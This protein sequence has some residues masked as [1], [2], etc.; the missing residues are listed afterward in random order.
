MGHVMAQL[1]ER[2]TGLRVRVGLAGHEANHQALLSGRIDL[3][4]DYLGT[5][6]RRYLELP[7]VRGVSA[8]YRAVR[9]AA[10]ARWGIEWLSA[11]GFN[12]TYAVIL[13]RE[14]AK[15]LGASR[16]SDLAQHAAKTRLGGT[17]QF[18]TSDA[19]LTFAPG[20][21]QGFQRAYFGFGAT[22]ELPA[23]YGATF[24]AL[25]NDQVD[26]V[27]DFPVNP[28][29]ISLD[30][31]ELRDDKRFFAPYFAA[32]VVSG[33]WLAEHPEARTILERLANTIDNRR[34]ARMNHAVEMGYRDPED[35]ADELLQEVSGG[36]RGRRAGR[37]RAD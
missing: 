8:T 11:F 26:A 37:R 17:A 23:E 15:S 3:Y 35:V 10:R 19:K 33:A 4:A 24:E 27:I 16:V 29:M 28:R 18:L 20:G 30:L 36:D 13:R 14:L 7:P 2:T 9:D 5:A 25:G 22:A 32:P 34:A 1:L 21:W 12:N 6:L 31:V